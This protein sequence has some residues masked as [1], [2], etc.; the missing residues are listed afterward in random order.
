MAITF[1]RGLTWATIK[2]FLCTIAIVS[3]PYFAAA[4]LVK[5]GK[6]EFLLA[7]IKYAYVQNKLQFLETE[8]R[9]KFSGIEHGPKPETKEAI[10]WRWIDL[11]LKSGCNTSLIADTLTDA[12]DKLDKILTKYKL[13]NWERLN[14]TQGRN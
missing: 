5:G 9:Q 13:K 11:H 7:E 4:E 12:A 3:T 14:K 10:L 6:C 2:A 1:R 8:E